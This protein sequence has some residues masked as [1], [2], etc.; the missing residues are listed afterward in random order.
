M[1]NLVI[2]YLFILL[3]TSLACSAKDN[4]FDFSASWKAR[5]SDE[6]TNQ[7]LDNIDKDLRWAGVAFCFNS[8]TDWDIGDHVRGESYGS[9]SG[10]LNED[11]TLK[12]SSSC[13]IGDKIIQ[14]E[15][16]MYEVSKDM[17]NL[18]KL[19]IKDPLTKDGLA[20]ASEGMKDLVEGDIYIK[21]D[22]SS[23]KSRYKMARVKAGTT[24]SENGTKY[25][26][27]H[28]ANLLVPIGNFSV[29]SIMIKGLNSSESLSIFESMSLDR[30]YNDTPA[31]YLAA[32]DRSYLNQSYEAALEFYRNVYRIDAGCQRAREGIILCKDSIGISLYNSGNYSETVDYFNKTKP[33][34]P[35]SWHA[36][37]SAL[38]SL[39]RKEEA[40]YAFDRENTTRQSM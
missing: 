37:A 13:C 10:Q 39:G 9:G 15:L 21:I 31:Y 29:L 23:E 32:A 4:C 25:I 22:G 27:E 20:I 16:F 18:N 40:E 7:I 11:I 5:T 1:R 8:T 26:Y 35:A 38:E 17:S 24:S 6:V 2:V 12:P 28:R 33:K 3:S 34:S 30:F 19:F 14:I 36:Y